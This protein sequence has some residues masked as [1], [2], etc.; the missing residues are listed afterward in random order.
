MTD[1]YT[2]GPWE[3]YD[4]TESMNKTNRHIGV[5]PCDGLDFP[6]DICK[7]NT[8]RE[9][10]DRTDDQALAD[11][12]LIAAA[13]DLLEALE[14]Y[15]DDLESDLTPFNPRYQKARAAILKARGGQNDQ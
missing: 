1:K 8:R 5:K 7:I 2:P 10:S 9:A 11:A 14:L 6:S 4:W 13:P 3:V 12:C 15:I